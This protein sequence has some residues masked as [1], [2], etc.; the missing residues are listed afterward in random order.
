MH[1]AFEQHA[2]GK[3][4]Y[5]QESFPSSVLQ[6]HWVEDHLR[7]RP[8]LLTPLEQH[9]ELGQASPEESRSVR[10]RRDH[11]IASAEMLGSLP[12]ADS[13]LAA[14]IHEKRES[15][16]FH[17]ES[18]GRDPAWNDVLA[19]GTSAGFCP[20]ARKTGIPITD[21]AIELRRAARSGR[22]LASRGLRA[23]RV[24]SFGIRGNPP[25]SLAHLA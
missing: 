22:G 16:P 8:E 15:A 23:H 21:L 10:I 12:D 20:P 5:D 17:D 18:A 14:K 2:L 13:G 6:R 1:A 24:E 9:G 11:D 4:S 7:L 3:I 25:G 19:S